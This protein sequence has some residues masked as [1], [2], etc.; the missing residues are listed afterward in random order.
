MWHARQSIIYL[1][2]LQPGLWCSPCSTDKSGHPPLPRCT[3]RF[4]V[5]VPL[6]GL[7]I[8]PFQLLPVLMKFIILGPMEMPT[9]PRSFLKL[10]GRLNVLHLLGV[11]NILLNL[12]RGMLH[13]IYHTFPIG[14]VLIK[15]PHLINSI[16]PRGSPLISTLPI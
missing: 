5:P 4:H 7:N 10:C 6:R 13:Y 11:Q 8:L 14:Q 3:T 12:D 16:N 9:F 15:V 1:L 2:P